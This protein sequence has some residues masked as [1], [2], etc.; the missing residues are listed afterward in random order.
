[1]II[2]MTNNNRIIRLVSTFD[3]SSKDWQVQFS[4]KLLDCLINVGKP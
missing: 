3:R 1:M 4:P 2:T